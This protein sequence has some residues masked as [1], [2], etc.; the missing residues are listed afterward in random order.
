MSVNIAHGLPPHADVDALAASIDGRVILPNDRDYDDARRVFLGDVD[1]R[2]GAIVRVAGPPDVGQVIA[3]A[4]EHGIELAVRCGGHSNAGQSTTDGGLVLDVRDLRAIDLDVEGKTVWAGAGLTALDLTT[5][6]AAHGLAVGFGD[7]GS[8]GIAGITLGGG[9][10]YLVRKH[11]LTIDSLLAA[12]L[13][14]ADGQVRVVDHDHDPDLFWAIRG[15]GGNFGV[16]TRFRYALHDLEAVVGG[17][18]LLPATAESIAAFVDTA[19]AAPEELSAIANVMPA[20]E[21]PFVPPDAVGRLAIFAL[22]VHSGDLEA[23]LRA[24]EPFRRIAPPIA[25]MLGPMSYPDIYPPEDPDYRP[26]PAQRTMFVNAIDGDDGA[27]I[28][29]HL[30]S[31]DS[32][33]RAVQ[34]R[35]LGGAMARVPMDATAFAHRRS[36]ILAT[37]VS[38]H[39]KTPRDRARRKAWADELAGLLHDGDDG[40]YVNFLQDEGQDRVRAA[41]PGPTWERLVAIKRRYDPTNVFRLNQNIAPQ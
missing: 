11:G 15:G 21:A 34:L 40:A 1:R 20:P 37:I 2:P 39:D 28:I 32:S 16:V 35:V 17:V 29:R 41:Y 22:M 10:G 6:T 9:I 13:V 8:V 7:T 33:L 27:A 31:S 30:E 5:A 19:D 36:R 23:G 18:L 25:D 26:T 12:E 38:F 4:G 14:T 3:F 24:I